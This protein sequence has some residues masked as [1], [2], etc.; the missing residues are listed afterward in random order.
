MHSAMARVVSGRRGLE[1]CCTDEMV[2]GA[3]TVSTVETGAWL[4]RVVADAGLKEQLAPMGRPEQ[5]KFIVALIPCCGV[6]VILI[7]P[8]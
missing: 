6:T 5:L 4:G 1:R 7:V 3:V 8:V 2:V